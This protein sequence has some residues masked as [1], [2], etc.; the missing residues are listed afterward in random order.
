MDDTYEMSYLYQGS[1]AELIF[2]KAEIKDAELLTEIYDSSFYS[3]YIRYGECPGYGRSVEDMEHSIAEYPK[4]I[5]IYDGR[6]VG[7]ISCRETEKG[8]YEVGCLCVIPEFQGR[9][10]GTAAIGFAKEYYSGWK[11]FTLVTPADK[12]GNIGFYTVKCGFEIRSYE[13]VG[14][15]KLARLVL[16]R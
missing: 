11:S 10:I 9:G 13:T 1:T 16:E 3:D 8:A 14:N 15:V 2:R 6:A 5:I 12:T 4:F 7:S